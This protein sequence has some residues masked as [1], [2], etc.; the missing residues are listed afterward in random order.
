[1]IHINASPPARRQPVAALS[2][3]AMTTNEFYFL[4]LVIGAFGSFAVAM[5]IATAQ[6]KRW[7]RQTNGDRSQA[8]E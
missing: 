1:L 8:A 5:V 3:D 7:V 2:E 4:L 6:Y